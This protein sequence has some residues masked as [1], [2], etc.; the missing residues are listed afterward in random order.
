MVAHEIHEECIALREEMKDALEQVGSH[1]NY[2][3]FVDNQFAFEC[4]SNPGRDYLCIVKDHKSEKPQ[5][6]SCYQ[7]QKNTRPVQM[8]SEHVVWFEVSSD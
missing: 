4:P 1:M 5:I 7:N 2:G 3:H 6:M 8:E